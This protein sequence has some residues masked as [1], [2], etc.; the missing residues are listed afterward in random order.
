LTNRILKIPKKQL[1]KNEKFIL[2]RHLKRNGGSS[3]LH[4]FLKTS[5]LNILVK[6]E[7]LIVA[8]NVLIGYV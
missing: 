8:I 6:K 3:I 1:N 2:K 5:F 4:F 7:S